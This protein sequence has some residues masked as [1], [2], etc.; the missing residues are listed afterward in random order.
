MIMITREQMNDKYIVANNRFWKGFS[1]FVRL[2]L[3]VV[4]AL[5]TLYWLKNLI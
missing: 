5:V 2:V 3:I 4:G 1:R